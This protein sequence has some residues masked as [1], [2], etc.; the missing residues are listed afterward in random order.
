MTK[1]YSILSRCL[2]ALALMFVYVVSTF[3]SPGGRID[4]PGAGPRQG[5]RLGP[6]RRLGRGVAAGAGV[7][8]VFIA[9]VVRGCY[10][11]YRWRRT[12][13]PY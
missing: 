2:A 10:W 11:S 9:P 4:H 7:G 13:C 8:G 6:W 5:R 3:G 1:R 12:I